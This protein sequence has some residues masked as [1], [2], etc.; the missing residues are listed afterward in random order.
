MPPIVAGSIISFLRHCAYT[1]E[2]GQHT[3]YRHPSRIIRNH[4]SSPQWDKNTPM[5]SNELARGPGIEWLSHRND[6]PLGMS[7]GVQ[8]GGCNRIPLLS[9]RRLC[10][11]SCGVGLRSGPP[12]FTLLSLGNKEDDQWPGQPQPSLR[13]ASA[14]RSTGICRPNSD[15]DP[16]GRSLTAW[17]FAGR[18][19]VWHGQGTYGCGRRTRLRSSEVSASIVAVTLKLSNAPSCLLGFF[20]MSGTVAQ[21]A[22]SLGCA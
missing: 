10:I 9:S 4:K 6:T 18:H 2:Y 12:L 16:S 22:A 20:Q 3:D 7:P 11:L 5:R 21:A 8:R 17:Y 1:E 15:S 13:S 14:S 19:A